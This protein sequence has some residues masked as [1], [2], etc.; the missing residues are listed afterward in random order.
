MPRAAR[1]RR[2]SRTWRTGSAFGGSAPTW[3]SSV[4]YIE[5]GA[6][7]A[8]DADRV[9]PVGRDREE[10]IGDAVPGHTERSR[11][12]GA[13]A[14]VV[15][16]SIA[17]DPHDRA[18]WFTSAA[19]RTDGEDATFR[20]AAERGACRIAHARL[21]HV[22]EVRAREAVERDVVRGRCVE[23]GGHPERAERLR[24]RREVAEAG[25]RRHHP[26]AASLREADEHV[27]GLRARAAPITR[28]SARRIDP[29]RSRAARPRLWAS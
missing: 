14:D 26:L 3:L 20:G 9:L 21:E 4:K 8:L 7:H 25:E 22:A 10:G 6:D 19:E 5:L 29:R 23:E 15:G 1:S 2:A 28:A 13:L 16:L 18:R 27:L 17:H 11:G 24:A 12:L